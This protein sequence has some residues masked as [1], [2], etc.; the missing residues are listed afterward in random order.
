VSSVQVTPFLAAYFVLVGSVLGSFINLAADRLPR[1]E[2][3]VRPRSH[4]RACGRALNV[5]DL[6]PVVG[7][8]LRGGRCA[9]CQTPIGIAAPVVEAIAGGCMGAALAVFGLWTGALVGLVLIGLWGATVVGVTAR[10]RPAGVSHAA[11]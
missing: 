7:Y 9:S 3:V 6:L 11:R 10:R 1:G 5:V 8:F 4:C 2:S